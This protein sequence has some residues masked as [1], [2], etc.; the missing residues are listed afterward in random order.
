VPAEIEDERAPVG[1]HALA[2]ILVLVERRAVEA[3][4]PVRVGRKM[5]G[6]P[7]ENHADAV[8]VA[9]VDEKPEVVWR[10]VPG[11]RREVAGH[12]V[13][14]G[15]GERMLHHRHQLD[16]RESEFDDVTDQFHRELAPVERPVALLRLAP[17]R[18]WMDFVDGHWL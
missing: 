13:A 5:A 18:S 11:G 3:R 9:F 6:H 14:P 4:K 10:A 2:R 17:P 7:V 15:S 8:T 12:L 1:L 16:V